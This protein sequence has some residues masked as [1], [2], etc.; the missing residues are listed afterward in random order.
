ML[1]HTTLGCVVLLAA[2]CSAAAPAALLHIKWFATE[3]GGVPAVQGARSWMEFSEDGHVT[4]HG[5]CNR[6]SGDAKFDHTQLKFGE[7]ASTKMACAEPAA[8]QQES[9]LFAAFTATRTYR[10]E[11]KDILLLD[12]AGKVQA[13]FTPQ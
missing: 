2:A 12:D 3:V 5:G 13:R 1:R 10:V 6:Y 7:V 9:K 8:M 4:G 11:G